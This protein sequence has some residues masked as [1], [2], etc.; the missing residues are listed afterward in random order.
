MT[1]LVRL[2][3]RPSET[4]IETQ[5]VAVDLGEVRLR[6]D[7]HEGQQPHAQAEIAAQVGIVAVAQVEPGSLA[8]VVPELADTRVRREHGEALADAEVDP[9]G[10]QAE[11]V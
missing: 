1:F 7:A 11:I 10:G 6:G 5:A 9:P 3:G 4:E 2:M 8:P